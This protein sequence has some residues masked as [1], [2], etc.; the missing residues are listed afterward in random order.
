M[1]IATNKFDAELREFKQIKIIDIDS[2]LSF[3][4]SS[5]QFE[6]ILIFSAKIFMEW[7]KVLKFI[8]CLD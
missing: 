8:V 7:R 2:G 1:A 3:N 6:E 5:V 4:A